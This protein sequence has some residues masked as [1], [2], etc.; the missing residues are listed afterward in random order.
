MTTAEIGLGV[1][2]LMLAYPFLFAAIDYL[3]T[4]GQKIDF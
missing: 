3:I 4:G 2:L 1:L